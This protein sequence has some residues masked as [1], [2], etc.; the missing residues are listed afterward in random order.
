MFRFN[1]EQRRQFAEF[2]SNLGLFFFATVIAPI[3]I[4]FDKTNFLVIMLGIVLMLAC[5]GFSFLLLRKEIY[6]Y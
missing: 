3:F 1:R 2:L 5:L 4:N 6:D